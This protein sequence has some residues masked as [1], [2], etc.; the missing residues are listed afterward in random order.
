MAAAEE[1]DELLAAASS[2]EDLEAMVRRREAGEPLAWITGSTTFCGRRLVARPGVFVP[3]PHSEELARRAAALL[4]PGA[5]AVDLCTGGGAVAA[6]LQASVPGATVVGVDLDPRAVAVARANGVTAVVGDLDAPLR[7][8]T[9]DVVSAVA[10]YVPTPAIELLPS[11]VRAH[12]PRLAL[13]GG[14]DGLRVVATVAAAAGRLLR[15]GGHL[16]VEVG[17]DQGDPATELVAA[18]G[19]VPVER[20]H[21]EHGDLRGLHARV[22]R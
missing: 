21:D 17:G 7:P 2:S 6:H 19:L 14:P 5:A 22:T 10:P 18:E 15:P 1:A 13:D 3:R 9:A 8:G 4:E 20:W 16:L 12:E 11:D